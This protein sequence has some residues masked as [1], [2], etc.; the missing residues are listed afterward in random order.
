MWECASGH[1][2]SVNIGPDLHCVDVPCNLI[3]VLQTTN[4][5]NSE[6]LSCMEKFRSRRPFTKPRSGDPQYR[7]AQMCTHTH[8]WVCVYV[9]ILM[10]ISIQTCHASIW[11]LLSEHMSG[12]SVPCNRIRAQ[13]MSFCLELTCH[14]SD[15]LCMKLWGHAY[16]QTSLRCS[17]GKIQTVPCI[18]LHTPCSFLTF[19]IYVRTLK[20]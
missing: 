16:T 19:P 6:T 15:C 7:C 12:K 3:P 10:A 9:M 13:M 14:L 1:A 5:R 4:G 8:I 20:Y 2:P 11:I 18:E 17:K